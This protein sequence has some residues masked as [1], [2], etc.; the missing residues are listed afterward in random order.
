MF[1]GQN[2]LQALVYETLEKTPS[3]E[4]LALEV[5]KHNPWLAQTLLNVC[6]D[7]DFYL[8]LNQATH[9][10]EASIGTKL[11]HVSHKL[12]GIDP[13]FAGILY[14]DSTIPTHA[15]TALPLAI[16][17]PEGATCKGI[18]RIAE[19]V[20]GRMIQKHDNQPVLTS[21][22]ILQNTCDQAKK[23]YQHLEQCIQAPAR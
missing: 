1:R 7:F 15:G 10:E 11:C 20:L 4:E 18:N 22:Q 2:D 9:P 5:A 21:D 17:H 14:H 12:L 19:I 8:V 16:A 3:I 6:A 23:D 13:A